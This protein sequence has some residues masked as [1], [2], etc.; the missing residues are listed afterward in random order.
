MSGRPLFVIIYPPLFFFFLFFFFFVRSSV[1]FASFA[2]SYARRSFVGR[3]RARFVRFVR[4]KR[5]VF[6]VFTSF[7]TS[8]THVVSRRVRTNLTKKTSF[9]ERGGDVE[10][11]PEKEGHF[12]VSSGNREGSASLRE[13]AKGR[14]CNR[15][16]VNIYRNCTRL[17]RRKITNERGSSAACA[18]RVTATRHNTRPGEILRITHT[19]NLRAPV[20]RDGHETP[21][22]LCG[23]CAP[24][25]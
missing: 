24:Q 10:N 14:R 5:R 18:R 22:A 15:D 11:A 6:D 12:G 4:A 3:H 25:L 1:S 8:I 17:L 19:A 13:I 9:K 23:G 16:T 21:D 20:T 7:V 2:R